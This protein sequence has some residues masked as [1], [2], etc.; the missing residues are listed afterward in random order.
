MS[1]HKRIQVLSMVAAM[2]VLVLGFQARGNGQENGQ[3]PAQSSESSQAASGAEGAPQHPGM[4]GELAKESKEVGSHEH[5]TKSP[6]VEWIA[7]HTGLSVDGAYWLSVVLNFA[8]IFGA[9]FWAAKKY[10]P[11]MFRDRTA[12]IQKAMEEARRASEDANRRLAEVELRLSKLGDEIKAMRASGEK[13]S[14]EEE[15]R[16]QAAA[17]A[18]GRKIVEAAQLEI[19]A[20]AKAARRDL[21]AYAADLAISL[22]KRQIHVDGG[23]DERLVRSF[24]DG[25]G[26]PGEGSKN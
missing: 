22:A 23:T 2:L 26:K 15:A 10:L 18:D 1:L 5:L 9:I 3:G 20:A 24:A 17:E 14:A 25:L 19:G 12:A 6:S 8:V 16:I 21:T 7:R 13:D 4:G 11:S